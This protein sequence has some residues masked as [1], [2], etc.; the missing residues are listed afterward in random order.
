MNLLSLGI[1]AYAG[2]QLYKNIKK[3]AFTL[4]VLV[5]TNWVEVD[6]GMFR[7]SRSDKAF[8]IL[9]KTP[10]EVL[11]ES[12]H[13]QAMDSNLPGKMVQKDDTT[14]I[15]FYIDQKNDQGYVVGFSNMNIFEI[16]MLCSTIK[17][18]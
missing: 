7:S 14:Y 12:E 18:E 11:A 3:K 13:Y 16:N 9:H 6:E 4:S 15:Y 2:S 1:L 17:P 10:E 5:P 8:V